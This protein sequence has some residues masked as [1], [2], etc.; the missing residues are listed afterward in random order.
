MSCAF[1]VDMLPTEGVPLLPLA[2]YGRPVWV[3]NGAVFAPIMLRTMTDAASEDE[4]VPLN[5]TVIEETVEVA[6]A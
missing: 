4:R 5:V 1:K 6:T 2:L 3:S